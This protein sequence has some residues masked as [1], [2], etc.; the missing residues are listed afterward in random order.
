METSAP[1]FAACLVPAC[2]LTV[3]RLLAR[4]EPESAKDG[5]PDR[6][7][8]PEAPLAPPQQLL[9]EEEKAKQLLERQRQIAEFQERQ[10]QR[11]Q[12][13]REERAKEE[14][15]ERN[16]EAR[17]KEKEKLRRER[18]EKQR[19]EKEA[20]EKDKPKKE[21]PKSPPRAKPR[22]PGQLAGHVVWSGVIKHV[23]PGL[24]SGVALQVSKSNP[25]A[26][27]PVLLCESLVRIS[28]RNVCCKALQRKL[29]AF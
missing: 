1:C 10:K 6:S 9:S 22:L 14:E 23:G 24:F 19:K 17:R 12:R 21:K 4:A 15:R 3:F 26:C 20:K 8:S 13:D 11:E 28:E 7:P 18:K 5:L 16:L 25:L 29:L 2:V 27:T